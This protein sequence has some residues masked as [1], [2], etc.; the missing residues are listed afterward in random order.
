MAKFASLW[1]GGPLTKLQEISLASFVYYGHNIELYV[2]DKTLDV[3]EGVIKRDANE[4]Y[5]ESLLFKVK[6][7][8]ASFSDMFRYKMVCD[9]GTTWVDADSVCLSSD[10]NFA[11]EIILSREVGNDMIVGGV[12]GFPKNSAFGQQLV[13]KS[14]LMDKSNRSWS[15]MGPN[16]LTDIV[17]DFGYYDKAYPETLFQLI[18]PSDWWK[19]LEKTYTN[20]IFEKIKNGKILSL[21]NQMFTENMADKN[22]FPEGSVLKYFEDKFLSSKNVSQNKYLEEQ[23]QDEFKD[24]EF[25][26]VLVTGG[27]GFIG[28]NLVDKLI[29]LGHEVIVIDNE[30]SDAHDSFYWNDKASNHKKDINDYKATRKLYDGVDV[31]FHLAAESRIG[32]SIENPVKAFATNVVGTTT[33]LQCSREAGVKRF[34]LSSTSAA[35]GNNVLP[36]SETQ[37]DDPLNPYSVSKVSAEKICKMYTDL[38]GLNTIVL[39]YFNVYGERQPQRGQYAPVIGIFMKQ[40]KN[41]EPLT[42]VGEGDQ[43]RDFVHVSDVVSANILAGTSEVLT[44]SFGGVYNVGSGKNYS[45]FEIA[46]MISG[47]IKF[48]PERSGEMKETLCNNN[49]IKN[50][51]KW[52]PKISLEDWIKSNV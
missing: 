27:A 50:D 22:N 19:L 14:F 25:L 20:E 5:P 48:V 13:S 51:L 29:G 33:V 36:N 39:R 17:K 45:I 28:S 16:L 34:I 10:W 18:D 41:N 2:Y 31:V 52:E 15:D 26:K 3:P 4:I 30:S 24:K 1:V 44:R 21:Y 6:D 43:K 32:P 49:K 8:Y 38:F 11:E 40:L 46:R 23:I 12:L 37:F 9:T 42:V 35:Y 7:S 47:T